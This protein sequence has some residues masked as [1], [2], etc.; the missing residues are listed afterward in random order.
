MQYYCLRGSS[1]IDNLCFVFSKNKVTLYIS[2]KVYNSLNR[3]VTVCARHLECETLLLFIIVFKWPFMTIFSA[4]NKHTQQESSNA[5]EYFPVNPIFHR[6][7]LR[8][9]VADKNHN[10]TPVTFYRLM[11]VGTCMV[12][13]PTNNTEII[14]WSVLDNL[15]LTYLDPPGLLAGLYTNACWEWGWLVLHWFQVS[16]Y[17]SFALNNFLFCAISHNYVW[18]CSDYSELR[19]LDQQL[20]QAKYVPSGSRPHLRKLSTQSS[21]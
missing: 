13:W 15:C 5:W 16:P 14:T 18:R 12:G 4:K 1:T 3:S 6:G 20:S 19:D 9:P 21:L 8:P 17:T 7:F 11:L 10:F 2:K